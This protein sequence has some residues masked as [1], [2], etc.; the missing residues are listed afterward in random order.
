MVKRRRREIERRTD[1]VCIVLTKKTRG[2]TEERRR[3]N[4]GCVFAAV[5]AII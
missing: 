1:E 3:G 4:S 2:L 5:L